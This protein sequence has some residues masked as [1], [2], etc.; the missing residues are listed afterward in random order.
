[1]CIIAFLSKHKIIQRCHYFDDA[2]NLKL[3]N[4]TWKHPTKSFSK[5]QYTFTKVKNFWFKTIIN[6]FLPSSENIHFCRIDLFWNIIASL[7]FRSIPQRIC[8]KAQLCRETETTKAL[9]KKSGARFHKPCPSARGRA[10]RYRVAIL[11]CI[12]IVVILWNFSA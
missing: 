12:F 10:R 11:R 6:S 5:V 2:V 3:N 7:L 1:M 8:W 9:E 4:G